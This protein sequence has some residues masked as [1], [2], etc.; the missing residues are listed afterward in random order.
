[1]KLTP[2]LKEK[3][4]RTVCAFL[5]QHEA[6]MSN[7]KISAR[8]A[9]LRAVQLWE[10]IPSVLRRRLDAA[11]VHSVYEMLR[12]GCPAQVDRIYKAARTVQGYKEKVQLFWEY[13]RPREETL[14]DS[15]GEDLHEDPALTDERPMRAGG[16]RYA[17]AARAGGCPEEFVIPRDPMT[18][19]RVRLRSESGAPP[20]E[21]DIPALDGPAGQVGEF[22][23]PE[24][25]N[26]NVRPADSDEIDGGENEDNPEDQDDF[27]RD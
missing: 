15:A 8:I 11:G 26:D 17:A 16:P 18:R 1:M 23:I 4:Y 24:D 21:S 2:Q 7:P 9:A 13:L 12:R 5:A 20:E 10:A 3:M 22:A 6:D 14:S 25:P 19:E 27:N